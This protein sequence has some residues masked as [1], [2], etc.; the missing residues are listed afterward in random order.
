[1]GSGLAN[2]PRLVGSV[3]PVPFLVETH[4]ARTDRVVT[5]GGNHH[6]GVVVGGVGDTTDDL[7]LTGGTGTDGGA[8]CNR[9]RMDDL[10]VF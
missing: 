4:P 1:M 6:S 9:E 10:P 3:N 2:R 5:A 8:N 7:E